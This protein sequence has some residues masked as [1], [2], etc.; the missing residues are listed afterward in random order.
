MQ[1]K[2][3]YVVIHADVVGIVKNIFLC[4]NI[5]QHWYQILMFAKLDENLT[6]RKMKRS[7]IFLYLHS[8]D[9][10]EILPRCDSDQ[11]FLSANLKS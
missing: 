7:R 3:L 11:K 6:N 1:T 4:L 9:N 2:V 8:M 10:T 5:Y